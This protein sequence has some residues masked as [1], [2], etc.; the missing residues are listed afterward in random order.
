MVGMLEIIADHLGVTVLVEEPLVGQLGEYDHNQRVVRLHPKLSG[1][2]QSAVLAHELGHAAHG[3]TSSTTVTEVQADHFA[4]W[5]QIPFCRYL[6]A[7]AVHHTVQGVAYE[8]GILPSAAEAYAG[9]VT[10]YER[11]P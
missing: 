1:L 6:Q 5:C 8:L 11:G 7:T 10:P 4:H 2:L 9:R 3:H